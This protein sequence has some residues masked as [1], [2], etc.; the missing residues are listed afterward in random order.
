MDLLDPVLGLRA[1]PP[2]LVDQFEFDLIKGG[3]K[4]TRIVLKAA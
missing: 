3:R 4:G 2:A 1:R